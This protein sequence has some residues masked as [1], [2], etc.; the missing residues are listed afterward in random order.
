MSNFIPHETKRIRKN[1]HG[2]QETDK[3]GLDNF[4][5]ESQDSVD[6]QTNLYV[7]VFFTLHQ[8]A[9]LHVIGSKGLKVYICLL[10]DGRS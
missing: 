7:N 4:R 3:I 10:K 6:G 2:Y 8:N 1:R 9:L 5:K